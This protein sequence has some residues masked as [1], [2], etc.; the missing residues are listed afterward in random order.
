VSITWRG[1]MLGNLRTMAAKT[2]HLQDD[3]Y[4]GARV[5]LDDSN[6]RIPKESGDL[7]ASG[8]I[9]RDRG[10]DNTVAIV[11]RGPYAR[12]QHEHLFFKH[13]TGG[14]S[15]FLE[16]AML[17]KGSEFLNKAGEHFWRRL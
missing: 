3:A 4:E 7:A 6:A 5:V 12:Y 13:P 8:H 10:G 2:Q 9:K 15:K 16:T 17:T 14:E 1:D 11:Y